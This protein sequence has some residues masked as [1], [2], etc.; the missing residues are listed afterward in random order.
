MNI[1]HKNQTQIYM[2]KNFIEQRFPTD[3]S[4]GSTGGPEYNTEVLITTTGCEY[5]TPKWHTPKMRFNASPGIKNQ[6]QMQQIVTFFR[7]CKGRQ[8]GFR[9]KDWSDF[10]AHNEQVKI[11][12]KYTLQ[13]L[14]SYN[15]DTAITEQRTI[16]KPVKNTV[17]IYISRQKLEQ[18]EFSVDY[19]TGLITLKQEIKS[20]HPQITADFEFDIP[21]RFDT[22][23]LPVTIESYNFFSLPEI[24]IIEMKE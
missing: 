13:L 4:Y 8:I 9:Y 3:I 23:Y 6:R 1:S 5:R 12:D 7:V 21:V 19:T 17:K 20:P 2:Q 16:T 15:L 18:N 24:S 10:K 14:K 22:D 11:V